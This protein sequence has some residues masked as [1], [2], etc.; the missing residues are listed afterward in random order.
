MR[1]AALRLKGLFR[2]LLAALALL[3]ATGA[4][5]AVMLVELALNAT[6]R[7]YGPGN[8]VQELR[9]E[10][11]VPSGPGEL[12]VTYTEERY[13]GGPGGFSY[14]P[15]DLSNE[16]LGF[17]GAATYTP[18]DPKPGERYVVRVTYAHSFSKKVWVARLTARHEYQAYQVRNRGKQHAG[19]LRLTIEF[20]PGGAQPQTPPAPATPAQPAPTQPPPAPPAVATPQPAPPVPVPP[21]PVVTPPVAP[22]PPPP[23]I[24]PPRGGL[25]QGRDSYDS[26]SSLRG[27]PFDGGEWSNARNGSAWARREL[28]AP[29]CVAGFTLPWAG[30]DVTTQGASI[31]VT[32]TAA[33]GRRHVVFDLRGVAI[34]RG[35]SPGGSGVVEPAQQVSFLPMRIVAVEV[36]MS[37]HG[38][39]QMRGLSFAPG[40]C[41]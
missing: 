41:P 37:G 35:F 27:D 10:F 19:V 39:F 15:K 32:L 24:A 29:A 30:S 36:T 7:P 9:Q 8:G 14:D 34:A 16:R 23:P 1:R 18:R 13:V 26:I 31:V 33:D 21:P 38:W 6:A 22:P 28:A 2:M 17:G 25:P 11:S 20:A 12:I 40:A 5:Q 4:A 3:A